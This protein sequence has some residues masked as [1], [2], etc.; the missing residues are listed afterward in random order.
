MDLGQSQE[1][2]LYDLA[3]CIDGFRRR[4]DWSFGGNRRQTQGDDGKRRYD[5]T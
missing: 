5:L 2:N 4:G 1:W 3:R